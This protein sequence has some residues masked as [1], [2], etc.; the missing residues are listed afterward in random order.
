MPKALSKA[1]GTAIWCLSD[2]SDFL[3][4]LIKDVIAGRPVNP[5]T[6]HAVKEKLDQAVAARG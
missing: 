6:V 5:Q 2:A 3:N 4:I 1:D